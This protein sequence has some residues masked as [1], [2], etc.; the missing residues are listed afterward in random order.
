M[1]QSPYGSSRLGQEAEGVREL[2]A[3][4]FIVISVGRN[5]RQ[6]KPV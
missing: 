5:I 6:A 2:W 4:A 1:V 3:R